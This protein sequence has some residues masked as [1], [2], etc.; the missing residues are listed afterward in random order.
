M[1]EERPPSPSHRDLAAALRGLRAEQRISQEELAHRAG[2]S[3]PYLSDIE[4]GAAVPGFNNVVRLAQALGLRASEL[5]A[6]AE[7]IV[8]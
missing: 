6:R 4:T 5:V 3:R 8:H 7:A 1:P 2:I